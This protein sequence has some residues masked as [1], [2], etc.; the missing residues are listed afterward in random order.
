MLVLVEGS[1]LAPV[2]LALVEGAVLLQS[3]VVGERAL[4]LHGLTARAPLLVAFVILKERSE[5][6]PLGSFAFPIAGG[7]FVCA[8]QLGSLAPPLDVSFPF[9]PCQGQLLLAACLHWGTLGWEGV[10][11]AP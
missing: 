6:D 3:P 11:D 9:L 2:V 4:A 8:L 5:A 10:L 7:S 1:G